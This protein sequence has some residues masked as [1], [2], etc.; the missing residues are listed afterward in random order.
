MQV[1]SG[2][3]TTATN[4]VPTEN[5]AGAGNDSSS[6]ED[7][8]RKYKDTGDVTLAARALESDV[9]T[10]SPA[11]IKY[12]AQGLWEKAK[13]AGFNQIADAANNIYN[14]E[15]DGSFSAPD[16]KVA[17]DKAMNSDFGQSPT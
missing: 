16:S 7:M 17:L 6:F 13:A 14:S 2:F 3:S 12:E 11:E 4:D 8:F 10:L 5:T 1:S 9:S 15:S